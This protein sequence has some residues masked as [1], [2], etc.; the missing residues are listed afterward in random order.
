SRLSDS[1][2]TAL[3]L[4]GGVIHVSIEGEDERIYS[5]HLSCPFDGLS[6]DEIAPRNFSFNTPYGACPDCTGLGVKM[7]IDPELV[8]PNKALSLE[9]GAIIPWSRTAASNTWYFRILEAAAKKHGFRTD[10]PVK[11]LDPKD[12]EL[13]LYGDPSPVTVVYRGHSGH[14]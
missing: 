11:D 4:G 8:L 6:F 7:E 1:I 2:E 13:I 5:E 10:V 9:E 14:Q 3:K 12:L